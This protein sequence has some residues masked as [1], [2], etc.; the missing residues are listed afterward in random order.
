MET[1]YG[2]QADTDTLREAHERQKRIQRLQEQQSAVSDTMS[3]VPGTK[4]GLVKVKG[5]PKP[6]AVARSTSTSALPSPTALGAIGLARTPSGDNSDGA[7]TAAAAPRRPRLAGSTATSPFQAAVDFHHQHPAGPAQLR[8][9]TQS[10]AFLSKFYD[11]EHRLPSNIPWLA[12]PGAAAASGFGRAESPSVFGRRRSD[13]GVPSSGAS[14][15]GLGY[16]KNPSAFT[17]DFPQQQENS[18]PHPLPQP[19]QQQ[20]QHHHPL[21]QQQQPPY[22]HHHLLSHQDLAA[23]SRNNS[24]MPL[25][26]AL[27]SYLRKAGVESLHSM[28]RSLSNPVGP[29]GAAIH[30]APV[31]PFLIPMHSP[32]ALSGC[33]SG[34]G[35]PALSPAA[36]TSP[37]HLL[38]AFPSATTAAAA[39]A[40]AAAAATASHCGN[41]TPSS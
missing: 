5:P 8:S 37:S 33:N 30:T 34:I 7:L 4:T 2:I 38:F 17:L 15:P 16:G 6:I 36:Y 29:C 35:S 20:Q 25:N 12:L 26:E 23:L 21:Q 19:Q 10:P 41:S 11:V 32:S 22:P 3:A 18:Q 1:I 39:N 24:P 27:P 28:E 31:S 13:V 14:T 40:A 9:T